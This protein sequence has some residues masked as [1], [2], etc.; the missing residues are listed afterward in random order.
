MVGIAGDKVGNGCHRAT[1]SPTLMRPTTFYFPGIVPTL[2]RYGMLSDGM[3]KTYVGGSASR[4]NTLC[5]CVG[6]PISS[7]EPI[8]ATDPQTASNY[9][10]EFLKRRFPAGEAAIRKNRLC[11]RSYLTNLIKFV[12]EDKVDMLGDVVRWDEAIARVFSP[13]VAA[14]YIEEVQAALGKLRWDRHWSYL[15]DE[16]FPKIVDAAIGL[17]YQPSK[18]ASVKVA[19]A[20]LSKFQWQAGAWVLDRSIQGALLRYGFLSK[21]MLAE[22]AKKP[23]LASGYARHILKRRWPEAEPYIAASGRSRTVALYASDVVGGRWPEGEA[24]LFR[25]GYTERPAYAYEYLMNIKRRDPGAIDEELIR[26]VEEAVSADPLHSFKYAWLYLKGPW[27]GPYASRALATMRATSGAQRC[28]LSYGPSKDYWKTYTNWL[29][30]AGFPTSEAK[31]ASKQIV[32]ERVLPD[33]DSPWFDGHL[34]LLA[35]L[36]HTGLETHR[37]REVIKTAPWVAYSYAITVVG[38]RWREAEPLIRKN[39]SAW[40]AYCDQAEE[41]WGDA[42]DLLAEAE[43]DDSYIDPPGGL[44]HEASAKTGAAKFHGFDTECMT[45][46]NYYQNTVYQTLTRHNMWSK[47]LKSAFLSSAD[48]ADGFAEYVAHGRFPEGEAIIAT[49]AAAVYNYTLG[50]LKTRFPEPHRA[51]AEAELQKIDDLWSVYFERFLVSFV[52]PDKVNFFGDVIPWQEAAGRV[53]GSPAEASGYVHVMERK[54]ES[55]QHFMRGNYIEDEIATQIAQDARELGFGVQKTSSVKTAASSIPFKLT[56][57]TIRSLNSSGLLSKRILSCAAGCSDAAVAYAIATNTPFPAGEDAIARDEYNAIVY[58]RYVLELSFTGARTWAARH[59]K[60]K[61][62]GKTAS[63][64]LGF[65]FYNKRG[66]SGNH[67]KTLECLQRLGFRMTRFQEAALQSPRMAGFWSA[68]V[69]NARWPEAEGVIAT[70]PEAAYFYAIKWIKAKWPEAEPAILTSP[71]F[72]ALYAQFVLRERWP[73]AEPVICQDEGWARD[74]ALRILGY[75]YPSKQDEW[76]AGMRP[77]HVVTL[78]GRKPIHGGIIAGGEQNAR[79]EGKL[80]SNHGFEPGVIVTAND[81][82]RYCAAGQALP[83]DAPNHRSDNGVHLRQVRA[84]QVT[85]TAQWCLDPR[86]VWLKLRSLVLTDPVLGLEL[87]G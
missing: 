34:P 47:K 65:T 11:W 80:S 66:Y 53:A 22:I 25:D 18:A 42:Q 58:A 69:M 12:P 10:V 87:N 81:G 39:Q 51:A 17:D 72:A 59:L 67:Q 2:S 61:T 30:T 68:N 21:D 70:D 46:W 13:R 49:D 48:A 38:G 28:Q 73:E 35:A 63:S 4:A 29:E 5:Y 45:R 76:I 9:A 50:A 31:V 16:V 36:N 77:D 55:L 57:N 71:R 78:K 82:R 20:G 27:V 24:T 23:G 33:P 84:S 56:A 83:G 85:P 1:A 60:G 14:A 32:L 43:E 15:E 37:I 44:M 52:A 62:R 3:I 40:D 41:V 79:R 19:S 74:Y 54:L 64:R 6:K 7:L 86:Q 8:L 26:K 75:K